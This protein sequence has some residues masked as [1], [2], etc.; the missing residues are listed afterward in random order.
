MY[1]LQ[2]RL[3][4]ILNYPL[5]QRIYQLNN[6]IDTVPLKDLQTFFPRLVMNVFGGGTN[7][8]IGWGL[9]IITDKDPEFQLLHS[10]FEPNASFFRLIYRLLGDNIRFELA[11]QELPIKFRQMLESGRY[12]TFYSNLLNAENFQQRMVSLTLSEF[13]FICR[14][15]T[16][17]DIF[18][19]L[20]RGHLIVHHI[21]IF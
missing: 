12:S 5:S 10:F 13:K 20:F 11:A 2:S 9:R 21:N 7:T 8:G 18:H 16:W 17:K 6:C 4:D 14:L 19:V 1:Q 3:T 15:N